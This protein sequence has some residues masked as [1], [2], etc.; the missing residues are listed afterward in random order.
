MNSVFH[1]QL[2]WWKS[3]D[4]SFLQRLT[5]E[6]NSVIQPWQVYTQ[7]V[8][9]TWKQWRQTEK[10]PFSYIIHKIKYDTNKYNYVLLSI[11]V[12]LG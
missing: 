4:I 7:K 3:R 9:Q 6:D 1:S 10:E 5:P 11:H 2:L 12:L 8:S